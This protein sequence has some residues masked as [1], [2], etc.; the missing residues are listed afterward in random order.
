MFLEVLSKYSELKYFSSAIKYPTWLSAMRG[1]LTKSFSPFPEGDIKAEYT[2]LS[3]ENLALSFSN[4]DCF[5]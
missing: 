3:F 2:Y 5:A 4:V 1:I